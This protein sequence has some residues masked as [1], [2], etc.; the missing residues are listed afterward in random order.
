MPT[1]RAE[2]DSQD[3]ARVAA[4]FP[5]TVSG[6]AVPADGTQTQ[7]ATPARRKC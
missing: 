1:R 7:G 6:S 2:T 4:A 5:S 3:P